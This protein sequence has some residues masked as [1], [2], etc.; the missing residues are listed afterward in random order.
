MS[1][2]GAL[3]LSFWVFGNCGNVNDV[4]GTVSVH[5]RHRQRPPQIELTVQWHH[6]RVVAW[7]L[8]IRPFNEIDSSDST[9]WFSQPMLAWLRE[10]QQRGRFPLANI[11]DVPVTVTTVPATGPSPSPAALPPDIALNCEA[12]KELI[13]LRSIAWPDRT[14]SRS[15]NRSARR[16]TTPKAPRGPTVERVREMLALTNGDTEG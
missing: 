13:A 4:S 8:P 14:E 3:E 2:R 15:C 16:S 12:L 10:L 5:G 9:L 11:A 7:I 6:L 1:C